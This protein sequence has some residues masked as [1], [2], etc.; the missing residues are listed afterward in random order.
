MDGYE[1]DSSPFFTNN[2]GEVSHYRGISLKYSRRPVIARRYCITCQK[3]PQQLE[4]NRVLG[5]GTVHVRMDHPNVCKVLELKVD[6]R[7]YPNEVYV[8]HMLEGLDVDLGMEIEEREKAARPFSEAEL[9]SIL[10]QIAS[11]LAFAHSKVK[12]N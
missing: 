10:A 6:C 7:N 1:L 12:C 8:F 9:R 2:T 3:D 4:L 5:I 11:A